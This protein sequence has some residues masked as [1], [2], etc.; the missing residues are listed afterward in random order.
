MTLHLPLEFA[1]TQSPSNCVGY[2]HRARTHGPTIFAA[3]GFAGDRTEFYG[4][5]GTAGR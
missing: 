4:E 2:A 1:R 5:D 3:R